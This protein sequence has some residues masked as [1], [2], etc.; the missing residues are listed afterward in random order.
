MS[1]RSS[2]GTRRSARWAIGLIAALLVVLVVAVCGVAAAPV[3][4]YGTYLP[5]VRR[6]VAPN[7]APYEPHTPFP[8]DRAAAQPDVLTLSWSGGDPDGDAVTYYVYVEA[9]N[10]IPSRLYGRTTGLT[11]PLE[12]LQRGATYFWQVVAVD[13]LGARTPGPI[14]SFTTA[15]D[16]LS[17]FAREVV[18]LTN[19][20]RLDAGCPALTIS[21]LLTQ[22][23]Q[24]HS[25][26]MA[27]NDFVSHTGS[28]GSTFV[29]R[30]ED[31]GYVWT[32]AAENIAAG[33]PTP[34]TVVSAWMNS[35]RGHRENILNCDL[36]EIGV[37]Y[38]YLA[39][40]PGL[41]TYKHYWTQDL[42]TPR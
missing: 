4:Q 20:H 32:R 21:P 6:D 26:D 31:T 33:Q 35:D 40:D 1:V 23:A 29:S 14:W 36:T 22:S 28:D 24:R 19:A 11:L 27:Y 2:L 16:S 15:D 30:I 17:A 38:T 7:R 9:D 8:A 13:A 41:V 34:A 39:D 25:D 10:A 42:A 3:A 18:T 37:G 12:G 5:L